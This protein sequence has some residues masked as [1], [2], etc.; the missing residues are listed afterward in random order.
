MAGTPPRRE[1]KTQHVQHTQHR[2][3]AD[4]DSENQTDSDEQF[5]NADQVSEKDD[6]RKYN[7]GEDRPIEAHRRLLNVAF[8]IVRESGMS[9]RA[10]EDF[11]FAEE[12]K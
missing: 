9:E 8:E 2:S 5:Y 6:V 10:A 11:V 7:V 1:R 12:N 3:N 4:E